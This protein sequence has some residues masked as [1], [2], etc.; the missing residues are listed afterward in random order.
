MCASFEMSF[1]GFGYCRSGKSEK[2][3]EVNAGDCVLA[4]AGPCCL[5]WRPVDQPP[6]VPQQDL[7]YHISPAL[8]YTDHIGGTYNLLSSGVYASDGIC[9]S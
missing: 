3:W 2:I 4:E 9:L 6:K 1:G 5:T 7:W 8:L